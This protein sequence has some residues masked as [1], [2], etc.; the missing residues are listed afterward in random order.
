MRSRTDRVAERFTHR[1]AQREEQAVLYE[2]PGRVVPG[3]HRVQPGRVD[4]A[5]EACGELGRDQAL[6]GLFGV[7]GGGDVR[8]LPQPG[9]IA[10]VVPVIT[11][12]GRR[13]RGEW[14][15]AVV[16]ADRP[17]DVVPALGVECW[18]PV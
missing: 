7:V 4:A 14:L 10:V 18:P 8:P 16:E 1:I 9:G 3:Q 15:A 17:A 12:D 5:A 13:R 2:R 6:Q 11:P